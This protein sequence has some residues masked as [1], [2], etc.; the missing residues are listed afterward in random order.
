MRAVLI[1]FL[2]WASVSIQSFAASPCGG[3]G[4]SPCPSPYLS[5]PTT[6]MPSQQTF[7]LYAVSPSGSCPVNGSIYGSATALYQCLSGTWTAVGGS[8]GLTIGI[9]PITSG[10]NGRLLYDNAGVLGE[11][12]ST[13]LTFNANQ[14]TQGAATTGQVLTWNGSVWTPANGGGSGSLTIGTTAITGGTTGYVLEDVSGVLQNI[15]TETA[16]ALPAATTP[17]DTDTVLAHQS[18]TSTVAMTLS[19][20]KSWVGGGTVTSVALSGGTTGL[21]TSGSPITSSGT[22]TLGGT[23]AA[24]N[25]G[26]GLTSLGSGVPAALGSAVTGSGAIVLSAGPTLT[27]PA[28]GTPTALVLSNATGLPAGAITQSGAATN[29]ALLWG[30][31]AWAPANTVNSVTAGTGLNGGTITTAGTLSVAYG[32]TAGTAAQ[33]N[34]SRL[35]TVDGSTITNTGGTISV[36]AVSGSAIASGTVAAARLPAVSALSGT[37]SA[38]QL[39]TAIPSAATTAP[40]CGSGSAGAVAACS[41]TMVLPS[42]TTA[43]TQSVGDSSTKVA[44]TAF[45]ANN[46]QSVITSF[47]TSGTFT[48]P[49]W[50]H[51]LQVT[52][53]GGG[54][55]GGNGGVCATSTACSGGGGGGGASKRTAI[56]PV[57]ALSAYAGSIPITVASA[58]A[59]GSAGGTSCFGTITANLTNYL[60][61]AG[62]G[63]G[64]AGGT[65]V[66]AGGGGASAFGPGGNASGSTGGGGTFGGGT[67]GAS[68]TTSSAASSVAAGTGGAGGALGA[69]GPYSQGSVDAGGGGASGGGISVGNAAF[70]GGSVYAYLKPDGASTS[71]ISGGSNTGGAGGALPAFIIGQPMTYGG[72]GGGANIG[73][74]G[75][76]GSQG[77]PGAGSGG[78]GA[79]QTGFSAGAGAVGSLGQVDVEAFP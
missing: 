61:A 59:L 66:S 63:A 58:A 45:V 13:A 41:S 69:I 56:Y 42:G 50:A 39:A 71:S 27:A 36:G 73:G 32:T 65:A 16:D 7:G 1:T 19:N 20:L 48:V 76:A 77:Q 29:Q 74:S 33:G 47:T 55:P 43:T 79:A 51:T 60:C 5:S 8:S 30:G 22:L 54:G 35:L 23:L 6:Y 12:L 53:R 52:V 38:T 37:V 72:T 34:D 70:A 11:E 49:S 18:S 25:G 31:S 46:A 44:T 26:T 4:Q 57:S 10:S 28:L 21:T 2:I 68:G 14:I 67:G 15:A 75:G 62:G 17:S 3:A 64:S 78:G 9:T 24:G 40:E